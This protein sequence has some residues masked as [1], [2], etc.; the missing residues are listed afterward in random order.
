MSAIRT[1]VADHLR[2]AGVWIDDRAFDRT[3]RAAAELGAHHLAPAIRVATG[4]DPATTAAVTGFT[5]AAITR[6][7]GHGAQQTAGFVAL[8]EA[9]GPRAEKAIR[10]GGLFNLGI[11]LF[12]HLCDAAPERGATLL[13]HATPAFLTVRLAGD[14]G[15]AANSGD[16]GV[17]ALLGVIT[18]VLGGAL[19]LGGA[20]ADRERFGA[21][22][23]EMYRG[24]QASVTLRRAEGPPPPE[25]MPAL[26][27]KSTLPHRTLATLAL[28][29]APTA[30]P[31]TR[32]QVLAAADAAGEAFWIVDDLADIAADWAAGSWSRPL[33]RLAEL[34]GPPPVSA[35][36]ALT[37]VLDR[38]VADAEARRL[39]EVLVE[40][41]RLTGE[42]ERVLAR[43]I[44]AAVRSWLEEPRD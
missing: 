35:A 12:D 14:T 2:T 28:L 39:A 6:L 32:T 16:D 25:I 29:A 20:D 21:L 17:D 24:Q 26:G 18:A 10:L 15:V 37:E 3:Q 8:S 27:A 41:R 40:L 38:G 5:R 7:V 36:Q 22:I 43:P 23:G 4:T 33:C 34:P 31:P 44:Q 1:V 19:R 11:T 13:K 9:R 30:P 42:S